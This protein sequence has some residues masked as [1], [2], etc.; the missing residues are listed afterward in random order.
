MTTHA[1][2]K[3]SVAIHTDDL[4]IVNCLRALSR[5]GVVAPKFTV[6]A[7]NRVALE[8]W[9]RSPTL[10]QEWSLRTRIL[11][12][13]A[14]EE[15]PRAIARRLEISPNTV[16]YWRRRYRRLP[17]ASSVADCER[18]AGRGVASHTPRAVGPR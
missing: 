13:S 14:A 4:A 18:R 8:G 9:L 7:R 12:A 11:L 16:C 3:F 6:K 10:P 17:V 15:G 5:H 1:D 2:H